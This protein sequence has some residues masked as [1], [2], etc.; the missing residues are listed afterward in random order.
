MYNFKQTIEYSS[1]SAKQRALEQLEDKMARL[2]S[3]IDAIESRLKNVVDESCPI[4]FCEITSPSLTPCCRNLFC[5][6]CIC[7]SLKQRHTCPLCRE[8][9]SDIHAI[10][11]LNDGSAPTEDKP[12]EEKNVPLS[13]AETL[14]DFLLKN[15][16]A[17]VLMFSGY[18]AT[19]DSLT[20]MLV[21]EGITHATLNGTNARISRLIKDFEKG[22]YRVL[23]LNAKNMGAGLNIRP[24]THV[25]LY[26]RMAIETQNQIIG[27][28]VRLGRTEPLTVVHLLHGNEMDGVGAAAEELETEQ[29]VITHE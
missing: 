16:E 7:A 9:I 28:A 2:Q 29:N 27:R 20:S 4:C 24:A 5:F 12:I 19:F 17:R 1:E 13:K 15:P 18:D 6:G 8:I 25:V 23:F 14:R 22:K 11:V 26:H 21:N 3:R 10:Q